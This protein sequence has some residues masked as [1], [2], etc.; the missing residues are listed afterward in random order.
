MMSELSLNAPERERRKEPRKRVVLRG[1]V[2][3]SDGVFSIDCL[4]RNISSRGA[5]ISVEKGVAIPSCVY[6]IDIR[7]GV[8]YAAEV[9]SIQGGTFGL[10]FSRTYKLAELTEPGLKYLKYCWVNCAR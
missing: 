5:R 1:K 6:L 2:V 8:A 3:Y 7:S 4:I 10:R 9:T